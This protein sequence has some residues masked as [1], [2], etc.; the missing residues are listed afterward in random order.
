MVNQRETRSHKTRIKSIAKMESNTRIIG[1]QARTWD[2]CVFL[3]LGSDRHNSIDTH[4]N[5]M[6]KTVS[7]YFVDM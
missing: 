5:E 7:N 2:T 1:G 3:C 6:P 4:T